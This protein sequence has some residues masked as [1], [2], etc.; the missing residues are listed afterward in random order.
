MKRDAVNPSRR[1]GRAERWAGHREQRRTELVEA[2]IEAIRERGA[3]V[4]VAAIAAQAGVTKPVLYRHF[5]DRAD[6]QRAVSERAA[7]MLL[8]RLLPELA[9]ERDPI[10]RIRAI[11]DAFLAGIEDEPELWRFVV[12]NPGGEHEASA[13]VVAHNLALI[14][15]MITSGLVEELRARGRDAGGAEAWA[16]GI[17]GM[18]Y[19]A[20]DWWLQR[21]TMTRDALTDYLTQLIWGGLSG[22][23]GTAAPAQKDEDG[24]PLRLV[25]GEQ[26]G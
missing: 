2:A 20:G 1:S 8:D 17:A 12:H 16:Y 18:V 7:R 4:S 22:V 19:T 24:R 26:E 9:T 5:T 23:L 15:G 3:G 21:R 13:D 11:V 6:L 14:A 10:E 25:A